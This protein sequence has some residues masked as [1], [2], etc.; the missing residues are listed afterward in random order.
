M[1]QPFYS[2][3][4]PGRTM[5]RFGVVLG[6]DARQCSQEVTRWVMQEAVRAGWKLEKSEDRDEGLVWTPPK[7]NL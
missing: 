7:D 3:E 5:S 4:F 2:R 1:T 6:A